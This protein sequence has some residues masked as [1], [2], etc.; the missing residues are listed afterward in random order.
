MVAM[1]ISMKLYT[2][3]QFPIRCS[4]LTVSHGSDYRYAGALGTG[5]RLYGL[6]KR[7]RRLVVKDV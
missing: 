3:S 5:A 1:A 6:G 4:N 2:I 7:C